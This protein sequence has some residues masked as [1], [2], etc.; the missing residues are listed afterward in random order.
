MQQVGVA[1]L[2]KNPNAAPLI[3]IATANAD[4]LGFFITVPTELQILVCFFRMLIRINSISIA[5][6]I[7]I[8]ANR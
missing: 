2:I 3:K 4:T 6:K 5:P 1:Y 7:F 8:T